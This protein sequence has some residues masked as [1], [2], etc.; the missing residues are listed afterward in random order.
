MKSIGPQFMVYMFVTLYLKEQGTGTC[1][2]IE[3]ISEATNEGLVL[4]SP[5]SLL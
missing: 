2:V 4:L 5:L 1:T 3:L